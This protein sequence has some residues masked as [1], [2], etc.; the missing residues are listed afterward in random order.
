M[1]GNRTCVPLGTWVCARE[2]AR[3]HICEEVRTRGS[4]S[5]L[6]S[7]LRLTNQLQFYTIFTDVLLARNRRGHTQ[8]DGGGCERTCAGQTCADTRSQRA[9]C[10]S[11]ASARH[12][13]NDLVDHRRCTAL[14]HTQLNGLVELALRLD[15]SIGGNRWT[16]PHLFKLGNLVQPLTSFA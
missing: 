7:T 5:Y 2:L 13:C 6:V 8:P 4:L 15:K 16:E 12:A 1:L 11:R 3:V 14:S 10:T 9:R